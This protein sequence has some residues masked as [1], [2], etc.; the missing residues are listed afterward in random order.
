MARGDIPLDEVVYFDFITSNPATG[1]AA[2]ADSTPT[3]EVFEE[4]TDTD[5]G[6]GGNATKR[7][8]K[9]GNYRVSFTVSAVNGFEV[10][11]FYSVVA[12]ATVGGVA[13]KGAIA[14]FRI[15]AAETTVGVPNVNVVSIVDGVIT[16]A[17]FAANALDAVWSTTTRVLTAGTNIALAKGT[18]VTG[19]ND[20]SAAQVNAE[21]DTALTDYD[22]PTRAEATTDANSIL[23]AI[24]SLS[25][26]SA[27]S[28]A[29]A[30]WAVA[31]SGLTTAG[32]IGKLL[33]DNVN[34]TISSR[35][36]GASYTA[37]LDAAGTRTAVGLANP[38]LDT[39]LAAIDSL[40][41]GILADTAEIGAAGAGLTAIPWNASWDAQVESEVAD[42]LEATIADSIPADGSRPSVKQALYMLTQ[43]ML[44]K[45]VSGTTVTVKKPDGTTAL[46]TLTLDDATSPASITR[47]T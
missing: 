37:P 15:C 33:V 6:V 39:Q 1:A 2:D 46:F 7:T 11:K 9:T 28:I 38:D 26:P 5:I 13:G 19:F 32:T 10:G 27:A 18:G 29:A 23:S 45:S 21:V 34:A 31:T 12:S 42:A 30:V 14:G 43:F 47:A 22:G 25:I 16:A 41:T 8:S 40:A 3:F 35:L 20:L 44:E 24:G 4:G 36:A 17:K